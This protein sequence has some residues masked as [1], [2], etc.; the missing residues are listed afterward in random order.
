MR[1]CFLLT[2]ASRYFYDAE[3]VRVSHPVNHQF[4]VEKS[5]H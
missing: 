5:E 4:L 3:A 2:K 1:K